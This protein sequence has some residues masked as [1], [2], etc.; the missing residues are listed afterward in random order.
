MLEKVVREKKLALQVIAGMKQ[1]A[2]KDIEEK[3]L[4]FTERQKGVGPNAISPNAPGSIV[5]VC[6]H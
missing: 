1:N 2:V 5:R 3:T 4:E 6:H